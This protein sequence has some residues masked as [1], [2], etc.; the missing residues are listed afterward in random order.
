MDVPSGSGLGTSSTLVVAMIAAFAEW[1]QFP[2]GE[3]DIAQLAYIIEREDLKMEGGRQ[4]QYAAAFGG[5]NFMEFTTQ[6]NTI[7]NPLNLRTKF[8]NEL[9]FSL[10]LY[11]T[12][13][14]RESAH[15]IQRQQANIHKKESESIEA[16]HYLKQK[17]FDMKEV[18]LRGD[19][20]TFGKLLHESWLQKKR[21]AQGISTAQIDLIYHAAINAG[22]LGGKISGAGGGGFMMFYAESTQR[23]DV[24]R[25]LKEFGGT[26]L[27]YQF[28]QTGVEQ[29]RVN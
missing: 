12:E 24:V 27:P 13:T 9:A 28:T 3:Y 21:M 7:V 20:S 19:F 17:A 18:L 22:A 6:G 4:D 16:T 10:I 29:W 15:I 1:L 23:Y 5:F 11:F 14:S 25:A 26:V 8:R 2:L